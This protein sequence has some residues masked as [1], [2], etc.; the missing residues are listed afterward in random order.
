MT[1][2]KAGLPGL[3]GGP[4]GVAGK[5][6][7]CWPAYFWQPAQAIESPRCAPC[8]SGAVSHSRGRR[9][10]VCARPTAWR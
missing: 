5:C 1:S 9:L 3:Q 8:V 10:P 7:C 6:S 4:A 2:F